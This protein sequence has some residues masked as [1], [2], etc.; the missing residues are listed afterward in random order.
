MAR[1]NGLIQ[2]LITLEAL[3]HL[4]KLVSYSFQLNQIIIA[5]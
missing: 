4:K 1:Q 5:A 2:H 3:Y